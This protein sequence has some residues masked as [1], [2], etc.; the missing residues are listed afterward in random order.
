MKNQ[1][2]DN[3]LVCEFGSLKY[4]KGF[5]KD[6]LARCRQCSYVATHQKK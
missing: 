4:L 6:H 1:S 5:E 3:G 2:I